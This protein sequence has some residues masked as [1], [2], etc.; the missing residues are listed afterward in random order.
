M[1]SR[2]T[3]RKPEGRGERVQKVLAGIGIGSRREID[4]LVQS[5]RVVIDGRPAAPGDRLTGQEKV[6]VD[7]KR[8]HLG[9]S[10]TR[11]SASSAEVLLY[12]KPAGEISARR[13]P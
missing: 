3:S 7:G 5:G 9:S 12:H 13:D 6:L 11:A 8:I 2:S 1:S 4:R 10:R